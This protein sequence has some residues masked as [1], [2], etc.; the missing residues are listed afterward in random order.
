[1]AEAI[2]RGSAVAAMIAACII[3]AVLLNRRS[4]VG[5]TED[6]EA[7]EQSGVIA[8]AQA[9]WAPCGDSWPMFRGGQSLLGRA[10]G[11][12][13]DSLTPAWKFKTGDQIKSSPAI[14][15]GIVYIG[16]SDA[17]VYAIDLESGARDGKA[18]EES[19]LTLARANFAIGFPS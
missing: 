9:R 8:P 14:D 12:V 1:M 10:A 3:F 18:S 16:S 4:D 13:A 15:N 11:S 17:N 5:S 2:K 6:A 19:R 7:P